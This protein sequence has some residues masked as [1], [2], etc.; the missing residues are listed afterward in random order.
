MLRLWMRYYLIL[1]HFQ[2]S[3]EVPLVHEVPSVPVM[4]INMIINGRQ[5]TEKEN[6]M[7][8]KLSFRS[9]LGR[10]VYLQLNLALQPHQGHLGNP[11][12][13]TGAKCCK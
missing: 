13:P 9:S 1:H 8:I 11:V 7:M 6:I 5:Q 2:I 4:N 12:A 10:V 3:Q